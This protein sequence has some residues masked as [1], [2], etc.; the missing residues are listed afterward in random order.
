VSGFI[1]L[2]LALGISVLIIA[3]FIFLVD[4]ELLDFVQTR[5]YNPS[6]FNSYVKENIIDADIAQ[7]QIF[8]LQEKFEASLKN[9]SVRRSFLYNQS[10]EDIFERSRIFGILLETTGGLQSI[11]FVDSNGLRLHYSTSPRDIISQNINSTAYRNYNE[12]ALALP[13]ETVS[14][15]QGSYA[16][17]TIDDKTDRIIFSFPFNDSMDVYRGTALF[18]VSVRALAEKLI[19]EGRLKVN[20]DVSLIGN[21]PGILLGSPGSS[22]SEILEK[23]S[24]IWNNGLPVAV[25]TTVQDFSSSNHTFFNRVTIDAAD[26]GVKYSL[27]S[28]KTDRGLFFGRLTNDHLFII[29]DSMKLI[30]LLSIFLSIFLTL[31]FIFNLKPNSI[32]L[33]RNRIKHLRENLFEQLYINKTSQERA[34]WILELEQRREEIR[35]E[36]KR[37][38]VLGKRQR[39]NVD[40]IID[41]SWDELLTVIKSGSNEQS[42]FVQRTENKEQKT[43]LETLEEVETLEE[44]DEAEELEEVE[45]LEEIDEAEELEEVETLEEI[46]EAEELEEVEALEEIDE[47]EELEEVEALEEIDALEEVEALEEIDEAEELEAAGELEELEE[48]EEIETLEE[49]DVLEDTEKLVYAVKENEVFDKIEIGDDIDFIDENENEEIEVDFIIEA[50]SFADL[51]NVERSDSNTEDEPEKTLISIDGLRDI[52]DKADAEVYSKSIFGTSEGLLKKAEKKSKQKRKGLLEAA[53]NIYLKN[54]KGKGLLATASKFK[55]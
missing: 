37:N 48:L 26:S 7:N 44:I 39:K 46:D 25:L 43:E 5:F 50:P 35:A 13:Y 33:V 21:P 31:F 42:L 23:I 24:A 36:L 41:K 6:V 12:D 49:L 47:A 16:K 28:L 8:D 52:F 2:L 32:T 54:N 18:T 10:N 51:E 29:S 34:K 19:A 38:L 55:R 1:K 40:S 27:V 11:Q 9:A 17:F 53:N 15:L 22:K 14:A 30:L 45:A 4:F 20:E 3:G